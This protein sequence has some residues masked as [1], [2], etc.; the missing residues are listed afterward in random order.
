MTE[1]VNSNFLGSTPT[2]VMAGEGLSPTL[3]NGQ[4]IHFTADEACKAALV[5]TVYPDGSTVDLVAFANGVWFMTG[6]AKGEVG[7]VAT[8]HLPADHVE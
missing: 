1:P 7:A 8:W 3:T 2:G 4:S 5:T 6:V